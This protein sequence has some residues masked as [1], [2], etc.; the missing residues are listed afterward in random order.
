MLDLFLFTFHAIGPIVGM[1]VLGYLLK[2]IKITSYEFLK[3]ANKLVFRVCLPVLL[4]Y[5]VYEIQDLQAVEWRAVAYALGAIFILFFLGWMLVHKVKEKNQKGVI[6]QCI[7]RSNYAIIG[8]PLAAS[9]GDERAVAFAAVLSAF[10]IPLYNML[11]V[12]ALS[13][14][15]EGESEKIEW[16]KIIRNI[17]QN[18]LI[19]GIAAGLAVLAIRSLIPLDADGTPVVSIRT[20]LPVLYKMIQDLAR[21]ASPLALLVMGGL[22]EFEAIGRLRRQIMLGTVCRTILAPLIGLGVGVLLSHMG[23]LSL[24][25]AEYPAFIA[26]FSTPVAVSSAIMAGEM[27][28]D[29]QLASQLVVWTSLSS[30]ITISV[31]ILLMK[32]DQLI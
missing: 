14:Y 25:N 19:L 27:K 30:V 23:V 22:F 20:T 2:R 13:M 17:I 7:Y 12:V 8:L 21:I 18:P 32:Y 26:L 16:K 29:E 6:L 9:L 5:N 15:V 31:I 3:T 24:T 1:I 10:S 28:N 4:F 11:A